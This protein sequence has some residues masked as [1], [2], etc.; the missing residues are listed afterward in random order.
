VEDEMM[1]EFLLPPALIGLTVLVFAVCWRRPG[2]R[3]LFD[4]SACALC[5]GR[6]K[7]T[8]WTVASITLLL[9]L[10]FAMLGVIFGDSSTLTG[11]ELLARYGGSFLACLA[12]GLAAA[13]AR[14][15]RIFSPR[16]YRRGLRRALRSNRRP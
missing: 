15:W 8:L 14:I 6:A 7:T 16:S 5:L 9:Y 12:F 10:P 11:G 3:M 1:G 13:L 2:F 4:D